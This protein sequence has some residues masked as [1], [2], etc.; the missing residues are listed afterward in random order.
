MATLCVLCDNCGLVIQSY[1]NCYNCGN[2][3]LCEI[4]YVE[5]RDLHSLSHYFVMVKQE[6]FDGFSM[7]RGQGMQ[8][9]EGHY[10]MILQEDGNLCIYERG[11][12]KI[13]ENVIWESK[14]SNQ[15]VDFLRNNG[16]NLQLLTHE[17]ELVKE[18]RA[19]DNVLISVNGLKAITVN[20]NKISW[21]P[22][23]IGKDVAVA[24]ILNH[25]GFNVIN[26]DDEGNMTLISPQE[27][28]Q[29]Q[30]KILAEGYRCI[31][32]LWGKT[33]N[34][35]WS[36]HD[37]TNVSWKVFLREEKRE[38]LLQIF[39]K[40]KGYFWMDVFC[41]NQEAEK[42]A[43]DIMGDIY[44]NCRECICLI[45]GE[46]R[47]NLEDSFDINGYPQCQRINNHL[48]AEDYCNLYS[49]LYSC[50]WM[51][52]VWTLQEAMLPQVVYFTRETIDVS[53]VYMLDLQD[54]ER[55]F[56]STKGEFHTARFLSDNFADLVKNKARWTN[57]PEKKFF[58]ATDHRRSC[59]KKEDYFYGISGL[60]NIS[61]P[62]D[63][64]PR[65]AMLSLLKGMPEARL[66]PLLN[67]D[68]NMLLHGEIQPLYG[69]NPFNEW[70][71]FNKIYTNSPY[72]KR[73]TDRD[74]ADMDVLENKR[75]IGDT[76]AA[77]AKY[78]QTWPD[79]QR[80]KLIYDSIKKLDD[81]A[82]KRILEYWSHYVSNWKDKHINITKTHM[83]ITT[84]ELE[85]NIGDRVV[86][87]VIGFDGQI[88]ICDVTEDKLM[89]PYGV[90]LSF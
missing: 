86:F 29:I 69:E 1:Y 61:I 39:K 49:V 8:N 35:L 27:H 57:W 31:S 58:L 34:S 73:Y 37:I 22:N 83:I 56:A 45:D 67:P 55:D 2:Y 10:M 81:V 38:K 44:K 46:S 32:H 15:H 26:I 89:K 9:I 40:Y 13:P 53:G 6:I 76:C 60:F 48:E 64:S 75:F 19:I 63:L 18:I 21:D 42:K 51:K 12:M 47:I 77:D 54:I 43:L 80:E 71:M 79:E 5:K 17:K 84:R 88:Y 66:Y 72:A 36:N 23:F 90:V 70:S 14:T 68:I 74:A 78:D 16:G 33:E 3:D 59:F 11:L 82:I 41:T 87:N 52:R 30:P 50:E 4:C 7:Q 25:S 62:N 24:K 20:E 85:F 28:P 65:E